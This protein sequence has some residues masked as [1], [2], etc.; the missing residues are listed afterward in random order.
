LESMSISPYI[1]QKWCLPSV[2]FGCASGMSIEMVLVIAIIHLPMQ[3]Q[4][5]KQAFS[6]R[7]I[8]AKAKQYQQYHETTNCSARYPAFLRRASS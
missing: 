6:P 4:V 8:D 3:S 7:N 2:I 5:M 1:N